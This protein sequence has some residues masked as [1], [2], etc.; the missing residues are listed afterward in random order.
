MTR[1]VRCDVTLNFSSL[2][3]LASVEVDE[4]AVVEAAEEDDDE[5]GEEEE[6]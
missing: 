1:F 2:T 4:E 5:G 6:A 3:T